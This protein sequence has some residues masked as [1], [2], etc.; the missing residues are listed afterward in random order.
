M[1]IF[2]KSF[3]LGVLSYVAYK[4]NVFNSLHGLDFVKNFFNIG[5]SHDHVFQ[6]AMI[7]LTEA[8]ESEEKFQKVS[9]ELY[10][11]F[12]EV[13]FAYVVDCQGFKPDELLYWTKWFFNLPLEN[14]MRIAKNAFNA[15]TPNAFRGYYPTIPG[16]HS[17]KEAFE[18]GVFERETVSREYPTAADI[19]NQTTLKNGS[20]IMR[21][22]VEEMNVWPI[23]E[24][25][26]NDR[27]FREVMSNNF[28]VYTD[29]CM[30]ILQ[31]CAHGLGLK[32]DAFEYLFDEKM[33]T[34]H[35]L[36]H[37]PTRLNK[38]ESIP[39]E[40]WDGDQAIV[41]GEHHD[42]TFLTVLA[43][44]ENPGLQIKPPGYAKWIDVPAINDRLVV[45]IGAIM[46]QMVDYKLIATNHRVLDSGV[47]R[48]SVPLFF[49]PSYDGDISKTVFGNPNVMAGH[50]KRYGPW[51]TNR[52]SM[53]AEYATTDFG[54]DV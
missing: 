6:L 20:L 23:T 2:I 21:N 36:I 53:F 26:E 52:T 54:I 35:R 34:T 7:N 45:N 16:G 14:K 42:S 41:T 28:K 1:N 9:M 49:E 32:R 30:L 39:D 51:M 17:F 22:V 19:T 24:D 43:T 15:E 10:K 31:L 27:K 48:Y 13:G 3:I 18:T 46:S 11:A 37:Y 38:P 5:S 47:D 25:E 50:F 8:K 4:T 29:A 44:F 40:A 12:S 33:L